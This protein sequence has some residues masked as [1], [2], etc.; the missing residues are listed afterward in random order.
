MLIAVVVV[1]AILFLLP[2]KKGSNPLS[3]MPSEAV[4]AVVPQR[5]ADR[6]EALELIEAKLI[7]VD[8]QNRFADAVSVISGLQDPAKKASK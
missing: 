6:K 3:I 5:D 7:E 1:I 8:R 4:H 2:K